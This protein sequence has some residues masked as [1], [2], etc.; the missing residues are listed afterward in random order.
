MIIKTTIEFWVKGDVDNLITK[1]AKKVGFR[2]CTPTETEGV[3]DINNITY[4]YFKN[5]EK[6]KTFLTIHILDN[7]AR[8]EAWNMEDVESDKAFIK[9]INEFLVLMGQKRII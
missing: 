2:E 9:S 6:S 3:I 7:R 4:C 5:H 1:S 8:V